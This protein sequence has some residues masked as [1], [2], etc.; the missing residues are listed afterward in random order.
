MDITYL[1]HSSFKLK[2][3]TGS[4]VIDP[5]DPKMVGIKFPSVEADV[6]TLSHV[7]KDHNYIDGVKDYQSVIDGPGEYEIKDI[8]IL[9]FSTFHDEEKG[10]V[11]GKNTIYVYEM[12]GLRLAHLG[13]LGHKLSEDIVEEMG[14]INILMIP[15]GGTYTINAQTAAGIVDTIEPSI[16]LPMHYHIPELNQETFSGLTPVEE[17]LKAA[18]LPVEKLPKLSIK[19]NEIGEDRKIVL[20]DLRK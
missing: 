16:I 2:G 7:H 4:V 13:D 12:D 5:F 18:A 15:V 17:F 1:G 6:V 8:S 9:G 10:G 19:Q 3:R 14:E 11:R 20:L